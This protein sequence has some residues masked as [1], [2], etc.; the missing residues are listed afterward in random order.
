MHEGHDTVAVGAITLPRGDV[1]QKARSPWASVRR[2]EESS[3]HAIGGKACASPPEDGEIAEGSSGVTALRRVVCSEAGRRILLANLQGHHEPAE[4]L[5]A[6]IVARL[7]DPRIA[8]RYDPARSHPVQFALGVAKNVISEARRR[9]KRRWR[10]GSFEEEPL[11][12]GESP[13]EQASRADLW[14]VVEHEISLLPARD[15]DLICRR[16]GVCGAQRDE[17]VAP[18]CARSH[19]SR[20][21]RRLRVRLSDA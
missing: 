8:S 5:L 9:G 18:G 1:A 21:L 7:L 19:L 4:D 3:P 12:E 15:R 20:V 6:E 14:R 11:D 17:R 16:F 2:V 10:V 13:V